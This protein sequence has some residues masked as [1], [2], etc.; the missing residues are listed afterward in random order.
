L[1]LVLVELEL[2][3]FL[4]QILELCL[5]QQEMVVHLLLVLLYL[6]QVVEQEQDIM[7]LEIVLQMLQV[8]VV[9][10][11]LLQELGLTMEIMVVLVTQ[12]E[13]GKVVAVVVP[14]VQALLEMLE[15]TVVLEHKF[16]QHLEIQT[17]RLDQLVVV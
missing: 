1:K 8:E 4:D 9:V 6:Y 13:I 5:H 15:L 17:Q 3:E 2:Q 14:A 7:G 10:F 16:H 12:V 11:L